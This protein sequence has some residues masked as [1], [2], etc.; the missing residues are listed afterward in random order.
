MSRLGSFLAGVK[1][2]DLSRHFPGP[3]ATLLLADMGA[4]VTKVEPPA[5]DEMRQIGPA[6][7]DGVST[8]FHAVNAG[9][10][11]RRIDLKSDSGRAELLGLAAT[12]GRYL[13]LD[14]ASL[15]KLGYERETRVIRAWNES[16]DLLEVP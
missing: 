14:T 8:P 5:G 13:G 15:S 11:T 3:L 6:G 2:L 10:T 16:Y 1:V 7:P 4:I 12:A 9:K